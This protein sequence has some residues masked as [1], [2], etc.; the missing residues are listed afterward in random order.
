[1]RCETGLEPDA[2]GLALGSSPAGSNAIFFFLPAGSDADGGKLMSDLLGG[3]DRW[4]F[5]CGSGAG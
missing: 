3:N 2:G 5:R 4:K 1:M